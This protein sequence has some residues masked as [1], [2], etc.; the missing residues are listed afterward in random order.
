MRDYKIQNLKP[1]IKTTRVLSTYA[2]TWVCIDTS[3]SQ[4]AREIGLRKVQGHEIYRFQNK[5]SELA[6]PILPVH[7][8]SSGSAKNISHTSR[9]SAERMLCFLLSIVVATLQAK[10]CRWLLFLFELS[11]FA[12]CETGQKVK[13]LGLFAS[14]ALFNHSNDL[15]HSFWKAILTQMA[16]ACAIV[17]HNDG[18]KWQCHRHVM[19]ASSK[20]DV[21]KVIYTS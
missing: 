4:K 18:T 11:L 9:T 5:L 19:V 8:T 6:P 20:P 21:S 16:I 14:W 10:K 7:T 2:R 1:D 12:S 17:L 13:S 15:L 3:D